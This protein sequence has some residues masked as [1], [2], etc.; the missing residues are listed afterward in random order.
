[1]KEKSK[2]EEYVEIVSDIIHN[3]RVKFQLWMGDDYSSDTSDRDAENKN[4]NL[5]SDS[6]IHSGK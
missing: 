3:K 4:P 2:V 1:M 5:F 6:K